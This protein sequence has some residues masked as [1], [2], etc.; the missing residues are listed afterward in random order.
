MIDLVYVIAMCPRPDHSRKQD[1]T[2]QPSL[3]DMAFITT[4]AG[5]GLRSAA[6]RSGFTSTR[7]ASFAARSAQPARM[8]AGSIP[9]DVD[10]RNVTDKQWRELL[11]PQ[12]YNVIRE[13]GTEYPGS[14][15]YDSFYPTEGHFVCRACGNPLYSA[16]SKFKSGCGWPAYVW[17]LFLSYTGG[18]T[19][20][21]R[22]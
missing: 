1:Q 21:Q 12:E 18:A 10:P 20:R 4:A 9:T 15:E 6:L 16:E 13:K 22:V 3:F 5:L 19:Q 7:H 8:M 11:S 14:G 17:C 2:G